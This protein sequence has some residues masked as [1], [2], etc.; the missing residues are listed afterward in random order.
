MMASP[1]G[2][3]PVHP[4]LRAKRSPVL[5]YC[6][7]RRDAGRLRR[8]GFAGHVSSPAGL[9]PLPVSPLNSRSAPETVRHR[10]DHGVWLTSL[11]TRRVVAA[12]GASQF[13]MLVRAGNHRGTDGDVLHDAEQYRSGSN[14]TSATETSTG[15]WRFRQCSVKALEQ[16][17]VGNGGAD[18]ARATGRV[19]RSPPARRR[20]PA[21]P[22]GAHLPIPPRAAP[23]A[24]HAGRTGH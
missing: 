15:L 12:S 10:C 23:G 5:R 16:S 13:Q 19:S 7:H 18:V 20:S 1:T 3:Q 4:A 14:S 2:R 17:R 6:A 8:K 21:P 22:R 9:R 24:A 11:F